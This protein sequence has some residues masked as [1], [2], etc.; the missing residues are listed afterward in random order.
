MTIP[1]YV[2]NQRNY[3][4]SGATKSYEFRIKALKTF[5]AALKAREKEI[6]EAL[7]ADLNKA[8][9]ESYMTELGLLY[10]EISYMSKHL[11]SWMRPQK[12]RT[13]LSQF[14]GRS[15]VVSEPYGLTL[16]LAPWN[17]PLL[18]ALDP[19]LSALA[20]GNCAI[21]KPSEYAP[22]TSR[23]IKNL[24]QSVFDPAY[25]CVLEGAQ[26]TSEALLKERFDYIFFTGSVGVGRIV[27]EKA[28]RHLTPVTL[29]LGGKSPCIVDETADVKLAAKRIAFG[30]FL[31]AGQTC[32][33]PDY[34]LVHK[35]IKEAFLSSLKEAVEEFFPKEDFKSYGKMIHQRHYDRIMRFMQGEKL[36]FGGQGNPETLQIEPSVLQDVAWDSPVMQEEIF[37]P[38]LPV[39]D[40]ESIDDLVARLKTKE[41]PLALYLFT[42]DKRCETTVLQNLSFGGGTI[43]DT[44]IHL[45]TPY[46]GFGG[47]GESGMGSYHGKASFETFSHKKSLIKKANYL[48]IPLRYRPYTDKKF[49]V[50]KKFLK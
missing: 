28:A 33:A 21:L 45:A 4:N 17:Y 12:V 3:F 22:A 9:F 14:P 36:V 42:K 27:M 44:I 10:D 15:F 1:E 40:F 47:V 39:L 34:V 25:V 8:P 37:G 49:A 2:E 5:K 41:K 26:E 13:P 30:K 19:M 20:A 46:M 11:K 32:V 50:L 7:Q 16:V 18:L 38:V 29:E 35:S 23:L 48:D 43:N 31:N 6:Y 24:V